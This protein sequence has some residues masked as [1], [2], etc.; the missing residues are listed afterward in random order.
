MIILGYASMMKHT[1][2]TPA[3]V[4]THLRSVPPFGKGLSQ[5]SF[6]EQCPNVWQLPGLVWFV[7]RP[8]QF[9]TLK[10][11]FFDRLETRCSPGFTYLSR[12]VR[13]NP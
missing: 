9:E 5:L 2:P 6:V 8:R 12:K 4:G 10:Y 13:K 7:E 11:E 1:E 3:Q